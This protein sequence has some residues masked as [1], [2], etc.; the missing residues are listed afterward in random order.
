MFFFRRAHAH[1]GMYRKSVSGVFGMYPVSE[2]YNVPLYV[3]HRLTPLHVGIS[4]L[5]TLHEECV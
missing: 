1:P 5:E 3:L 2:P 4:I